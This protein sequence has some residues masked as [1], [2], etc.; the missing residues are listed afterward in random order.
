MFLSGISFHAAMSSRH[1]QLKLYS[2]RLF[3]PQ[4]HSQEEEEVEL[5]QVMHRFLFN[6]HTNSIDQFY[7][8]DP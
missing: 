5:T 4:K 1:L 8:D 3:E 6:Y 2:E 7:G